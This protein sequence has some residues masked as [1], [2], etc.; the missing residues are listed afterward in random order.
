M[1]KPEDT[2]GQKESDPQSGYAYSTGPASSQELVIERHVRQMLNE[3][4]EK[5]GYRTALI[6]ELSAYV[7]GVLAEESKRPSY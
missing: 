3:L 4:H 5:C 2:T 1:S 6:A 7:R